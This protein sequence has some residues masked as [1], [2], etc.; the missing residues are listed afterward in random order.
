MKII[1]IIAEYNPFHN[2]HLYQIKKIKEKYKDSLI[3]VVLSSS[4]S[5]RGEPIILSKHERTDIILNNNVDIVIELPYVFS[6]QSADIFAKGA[7]SILNSIGINTLSFGIES[8]I[9]NLQKAAEIQLNNKEFDLKVKEYMDK[10]YNYRSSVAKSIFDLINIT[11]DSPNDILA[12]SYIKEILKQNK[13]IEILPIKRTSTYTDLKSKNK[14]VSASNI[15]NKLGKENI[16]KYV[17]KETYKYLKKFKYNDNLYF[18]LLKYKLFTNNN[19]NNILLVDEGIENRINK[20]IKVSNNINELISNIKTKRYTEN[21]IRR[22]LCHILCDYTK[23]KNKEFTDI[24]Y[25]KIL[26]FNEKGKKYLNIIKNK[27]KY[28]ILTNY[29]KGFHMLEEEIK[30]SQIYDLLTNKNTF[31][32]EYKKGPNYKN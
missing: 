6:T 15:R 13:N 8:N 9:N 12:V 29:K 22:T 26:G 3:I 25:I 23:E 21:K 16:K 4:F 27:T 24:E 19:L 31:L 18:K 14:I 1:G 17:P 28:Q 10:K 11:V 2:G 5:Q 20:Y 7:I 30:I 32:D